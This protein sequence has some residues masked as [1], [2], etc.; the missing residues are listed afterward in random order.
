MGKVKRER[1]NRDVD[2]RKKENLRTKGSEKEW[3]S[4]LIESVH[5]VTAQSDMLCCRNE[6]S[7]GKNH[8]CE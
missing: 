6:Q 7:A 5:T 3:G 2:D 4:M 1:K 8:S